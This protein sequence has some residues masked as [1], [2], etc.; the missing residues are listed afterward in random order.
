MFSLKKDNYLSKILIKCY[1]FCFRFVLYI[2]FSPLEERVTGV[3][4]VELLY[5]LDLEGPVTNCYTEIGTQTQSRG[6]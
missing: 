3:A 6:Q 4:S 2:D 5:G 1:V